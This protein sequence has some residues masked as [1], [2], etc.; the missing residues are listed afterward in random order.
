MSL[1]TGARSVALSVEPD[2]VNY[3]LTSQRADHWKSL[4]AL[5]LLDIAYLDDDLRI[6]RGTT[7]TD[8]I[9]IFKRMK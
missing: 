3:G 1:F 5:N 6:M 7:S 8:S 4:G 9:F 2:K